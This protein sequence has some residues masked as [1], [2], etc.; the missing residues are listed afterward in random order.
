[1]ARIA[2]RQS[3]NSSMSNFTL[4]RLRA[5]VNLLKDIPPPPI[6]MSTVECPDGQSLQWHENDR[7]CILAHPD[8]WQKVL[9][10]CT[11]G[12]P[13]HAVMYGTEIIDLDDRVTRQRYSD[14]YVSALLKLYTWNRSQ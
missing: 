14:I 8:F 2:V 12:A 5:A 10:A 6:F 9:A 4:E 3:K 13:D 1:M 11:P 7:P